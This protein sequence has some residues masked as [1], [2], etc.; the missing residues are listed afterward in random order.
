L[1][2]KH[3]VPAWKAHAAPTSRLGVVQTYTNLNLNINLNH[4]LLPMF[5]QSLL[6]YTC[7]QVA[8][9]TRA[10]QR[11]KQQWTRGC[12]GSAVFSFI[13]GLALGLL[14]TRWEILRFQRGSGCTGHQGLEAARRTRIKQRDV[15]HNWPPF[16]IAL[17]SSRQAGAR[18]F[19]AVCV[20]YCMPGALVLTTREMRMPLAWSA[21]CASRPPH[22]WFNISIF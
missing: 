21:H 3:G 10:T 1:L 15:A 11:K 5:K 2:P 12:G 8:E 13:E 4:G 20:V 7:A 22:P 9:S 6:P 19:D 16:L 17:P 18:G 14:E